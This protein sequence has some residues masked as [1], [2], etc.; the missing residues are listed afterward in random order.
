MWPFIFT[1][2]ATNIV[3]VVGHAALIYGAQLGVKY[4]NILTS[5]IQCFVVIQRRSSGSCDYKFLSAFVFDW[6]CVD[7]KTTQ[8]NMGW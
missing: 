8:T 2:I 7:Q 6:L 3:N 5:S 4:V 1:S